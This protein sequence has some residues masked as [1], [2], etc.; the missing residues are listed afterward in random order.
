MPLLFHGKT[1][2]EGKTSIKEGHDVGNGC[3][4]LDAR[5]SSSL[6]KSQTN[7]SLPYTQEEQILVTRAAIATQQTR[8]I[9]RSPP[10]PYDRHH[11][12]LNPSTR[13]HTRTAAQQY[14]TQMTPALRR[15]NTRPFQR[16]LL[17]DD[18]LNQGTEPNAAWK[19]QVR[20]NALALNALCEAR[21]Q[22]GEANATPNNGGNSGAELSDFNAQYQEYLERRGLP[23]ING[24]TRP[25]ER[26][27]DEL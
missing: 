4:V 19:K 26:L 13:L 8:N 1:T 3:A 24:L 10:S 17:P 16:L 11:G 5:L 18:G 25:M 7:F 14:P 20:E 21:Q 15:R 22:E 27:F 2:V 6:V 9:L 12:S 23:N